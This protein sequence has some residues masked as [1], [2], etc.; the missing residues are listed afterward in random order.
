MVF[1]IR[2]CWPE[3]LAGQVI[4]V[5]IKAMIGSYRILPLLLDVMSSIDGFF[6]GFIHFLVR[7]FRAPLTGP[8]ALLYRFRKASYLWLV[9]SVSPGWF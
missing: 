1:V 9:L 2:K 6:Q 3:S 4:L 5:A 7:K 8:E